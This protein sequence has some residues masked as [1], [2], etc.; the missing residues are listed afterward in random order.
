MAAYDLTPLSAYAGDPTPPALP[1]DWP[2]W[3]DPSSRDERFIAYANALL[4]L[5]QPLHPDDAAQLERFA[6]IGI[7]SGEQFDVDA[8]DDQTR[9]AIRVGVAEAREAIEATIGRL[10]RSVNGWG[11]TGVLRR[12]R[13]RRRP[14]H[15]GCRRHG[16]LGWQ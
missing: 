9:A 13:V 7:R 10:G 12:P 15:A 1:I 8:L 3:D 11:M 6:S 4:P 2:V 16:G 5:C 14:P